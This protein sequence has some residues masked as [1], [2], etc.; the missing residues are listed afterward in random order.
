[1]SGK[2]KEYRCCVVVEGRSCGGVVLSFTVSQ[3]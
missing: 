1:M 2:N 3:P